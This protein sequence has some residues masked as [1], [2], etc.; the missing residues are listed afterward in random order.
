MEKLGPETPSLNETWFA[1]MARELPVIPI[2]SR[3]CFRGESLLKMIG[4]EVLGQNTRSINF[5][6]FNLKEVTISCL[7]HSLPVTEVPNSVNRVKFNFLNLSCRV[8]Q[9]LIFS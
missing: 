9:T 4:V 2:P 5:I 3:T 7:H 8:Q 1:I 6:K